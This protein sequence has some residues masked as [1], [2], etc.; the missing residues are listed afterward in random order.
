[1]SKISKQGTRTRN[2]IPV[3]FLVPA[4]KFRFWSTSTLSKVGKIEWS[5]SLVSIIPFYF[6][7]VK[8]LSYIHIYNIEGNLGVAAVGKV[9]PVEPFKKFTDDD[10]KLMPKLQL[11]FV[12]VKYQPILL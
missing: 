12:V 11:V 6:S 3:L 5:F 1:M 9:V 2:F 4:R 7:E 10:A 8:F